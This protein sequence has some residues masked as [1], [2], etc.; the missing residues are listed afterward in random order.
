MPRKHLV[1]LVPQAQV[2]TGGTATEAGVGGWVPGL[3]GLL[4]PDRAAWALPVLTHAD[5]VA[6][7][8]S[9]A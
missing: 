7:S 5:L 1:T 9:L 6:W 3:A 2:R 8:L 4:P